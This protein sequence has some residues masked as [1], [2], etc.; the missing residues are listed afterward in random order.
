[1]QKLLDDTVFN[2]LVSPTLRSICIDSVRSELN[3]VYRK[4]D[5]TQSE[6]KSLAGSS[7]RHDDLK[8][9]LR[10]RSFFML[11]LLKNVVPVDLEVIIKAATL[12]D[13]IAGEFAKRIVR[14]N[15]T[16]IY[17]YLTKW[18]SNSWKTVHAYVFTLVQSTRISC[19]LTV[20]DSIHIY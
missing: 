11:P 4:L 17:S 9:E 7:S 18:R 1:M 3:S 13:F 19:T 20:L 14:N 15:N 12:A 5:N 2:L 16:I 6:V 8:Q 10:A